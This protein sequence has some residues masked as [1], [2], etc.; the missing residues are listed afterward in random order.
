MFNI[1]TL[2]LS[3]WRYNW[4]FSHIFLLW[5][6]FFPWFHFNFINSFI[7]HTK[8]CKMIYFKF[9]NLI[10]SIIWN[11]FSLYS[12][13]MRMLITYSPRLKGCFQLLSFL[14]SSFILLECHLIQSNDSRFIEFLANFR[15]SVSG[16][17]INFYIS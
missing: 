17:I 13:I 2:F 8:L 7:S 16:I 11:M 12:F 5:L 4:F 1:L 9:P 15:F 6:H 3:N 10:L 14:F